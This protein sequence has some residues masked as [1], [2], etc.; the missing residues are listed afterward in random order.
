MTGRFDGP[1]FEEEAAAVVAFQ[2]E[3]IQLYDRYLKDLGESSP[4][5]PFLPIQSFR[6][7][8]LST[9]PS[10][11]AEAIF[12]SS[13]TTAS[14][15]SRHVVNRLSVYESSLRTNFERQLGTGPFTIAA[16]LPGY[17]E[18]GE[19][20][21]L[22][23]MVRC[24][25][26]NYGD[27]ESGFFFG[28]PGALSRTIAWSRRYGTRLILF[29]VAFGLLDLLDDGDF[30]LPDGSVVIET[31]GMKT[32]RKEI[33]REDLHARLAAG[34]RVGRESVLSEYGMTE[35]LSQCYTR[36]GD[37][38]YPPGWMRV[39]IRNPHDPLERQP[40]GSPG[41]IAVIDLANMYSISAILTE[42]LGVRVDDGFRVIGR[43]RGTRLRGCNLLLDNLL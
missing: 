43:L 3:R 13:G 38:F 9:F 19:S 7:A 23:Y 42:D 22:L 4:V 1:R 11:Q 40:E 17:E 32:H 2:S 29:G 15:R 39:E 30:A 12:L 10:D 8:T 36:G 33:G 18:T 20:S 34:F 27:E 24:L 37:V 35:L 31:G 16:Y 26:R 5:F 21:S 14:L 28:R 25:I 41:V 6:H